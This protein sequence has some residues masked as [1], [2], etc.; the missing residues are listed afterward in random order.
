MTEYS[1][2]T[3]ITYFTEKHVN[4]NNNLV[5]LGLSAIEAIILIIQL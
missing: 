2:S 3:L 5:D 1:N 4:A